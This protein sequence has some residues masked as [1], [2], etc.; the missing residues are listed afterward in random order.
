MNTYREGMRFDWYPMFTDGPVYF[1]SLTIASQYLKEQPSSS[2]KGVNPEKKGAQIEQIFLQILSALYTSSNQIGEQ[3]GNDGWI[4]VP[5]T[6]RAYITKQDSS[7]KVFG[8]HSYTV[9]I[10][11]WLLSKNML[12]EQLGNEIKG[13]SR[14]R[15]SGDLKAY[16][17][18]LGLVWMPVKPIAREQL[19][20]VRDKDPK[21][22]KKFRV[23]LISNDKIEE[24]LDQLETINA[25]F[26]RHC[27]SLNLSNDNLRQIEAKD[28]DD[29]LDDQPTDIN[30][31]RTQLV[32]IYARGQTNKGGRFYRGWWQHVPSDVRR[33]I[34]ID[35]K[36]TV[37]IDYSGMSMR[38]LY[39]SEGVELDLNTDVY[40]LGFDDWMGETDPRRPIIKTYVNAVFNDENETYRVSPKDLKLLG[41]SNQQELRDKLYKAHDRVNLRDRITSGW[42]L[43]SQYLDS[44]IALQLMYQFAIHDDPLL[45]VHDSFITKKGHELYLQQL[46]LDTFERLTK[47]KTRVDITPYLPNEGFRDKDNRND[48]SKIYVGEEILKALETHKESLITHSLMTNYLQS[49]KK[50][51]C[52]E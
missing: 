4:A 32:R 14:Y 21:T 35:G 47:G 34:L 28:Y 36:K 15:A 6:R 23:P 2:S 10:V 24:E 11:D 31:Y 25:C 19:I 42:G 39:A 43:E 30:F 46:M 41:V 38:L 7:E 50:D 44:E 18:G 22:K 5:R 33:H 9:S 49:W 26:R 37:E 12:V 20:I 45:P 48:Y 52:R 51:Y 13:Y 3:S 1:H 16:L 27:F 40:N 17:E 8:S 29:G